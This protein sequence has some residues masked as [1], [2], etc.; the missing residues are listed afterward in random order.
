MFP[1]PG[2]SVPDARQ[3]SNEFVRGPIAPTNDLGV[4]RRLIDGFDAR[5]SARREA[6]DQTLA[7]I[8]SHP[9]AHQRSC[10]LGHL[11]SSALVLDHAKYCAL[12]TFHRNL[13]RWLQLGGHADGDANL[14]GV[15][16]REA[17][18]ESGIS[19]LLID[20]VPIDIDIHKIPAHQG[21]PEHLHFDVCFLVQA[22]PGVIPR[23]SNESLD[24][25]WFGL[26]DLDGI[27]AD[28]RLR[29]LFRFAFWLN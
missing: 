26:D 8:D 25:R 7:F 11:T 24:L 27:S 18:E 23:I 5:D 21:V 20:P 16:L 15:A 29:R 13:G 17:E 2:F 1:I 12:L 22:G 10:M 14:V 9:N 6:K 3:H 4:A 19:N 28:D